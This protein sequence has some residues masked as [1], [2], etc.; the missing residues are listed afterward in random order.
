[1]RNSVVKFFMAEGVKQLKKYAKDRKAELKVWKDEQK[2]KRSKNRFCTDLANAQYIKGL[3]KVSEM[4]KKAEKRQK[5]ENEKW[6]KEMLEHFDSV[7]NSVGE[8]SRIEVNVDWVRSQTW[9][10]NPHAEVSLYVEGEGWKRFNGTA[11]GCGYDKL[12]TA[13][14]EAINQCDLFRRDLAEFW[15]NRKKLSEKSEKYDGQIPYGFNYHS[16]MRV[17]AFEDGVG[18]DCFDRIFKLMGYKRVGYHDSKMN[19]WYAYEKQK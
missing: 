17:P 2:E 16:K 18:Y 4:V 8:I 9:G 12:S 11:S 10:A 19:D 13:V 14:A 5:G 3:L 7:F 1:M 6:E 15:Y